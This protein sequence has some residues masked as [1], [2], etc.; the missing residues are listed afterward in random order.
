MACISACACACASV[1]GSNPAA[2]ALSSATI[3]VSVPQVEP[4][5][6]P[7]PLR[8]RGI[9]GMPLSARSDEPGQW[10]TESSSA[11]NGTPA[12]CIAR[13]AL[14]RLRAWES[15]PATTV[16]SLAKGRMGAD[17]WL[18]FVHWLPM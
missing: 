2:V 13:R 5:T 7:S 10:T 12:C 16:G 1:P 6:L 18:K 3:S 14:V 8:R 15:L 9:D 4:T 11:K 17:G